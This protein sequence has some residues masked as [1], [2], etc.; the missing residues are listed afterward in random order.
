MITVIAYLLLKE[1]FDTNWSN[2]LM[3][4]PVITDLVLIDLISRIFK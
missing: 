2:W 4:L 3:V 1:N